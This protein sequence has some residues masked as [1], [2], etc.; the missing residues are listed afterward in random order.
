MY[1]ICFVLHVHVYMC[2]PVGSWCSLFVFVFFSDITSGSSTLE[3]YTLI[4]IILF[5]HTNSATWAINSA[6]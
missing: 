6:R 3:L 2:M 5:T 1:S 4:N